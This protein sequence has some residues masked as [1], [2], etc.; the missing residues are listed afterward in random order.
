LA[1]LHAGGEG[2]K[3]EG[4]FAFLKA[5]GRRGIQREGSWLYIL[6]AEGCDRK[7]RKFALLQ[8]GEEG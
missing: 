3:K 1:L 5:G 6:E 8:A 2:Y 7:G 4:K